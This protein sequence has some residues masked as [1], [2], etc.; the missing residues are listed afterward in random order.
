[1]Q[2]QQLRLCLFCPGVS[3]SSS[4]CRAPVLCRPVDSDSQLACHLTDGSG[5][6]LCPAGAP[7]EAGVARPLS[8]RHGA[9]LAP[10]AEAVDVREAQWQ[11]TQ[12]LDA[13]AELEERLASVLH[14]PGAEQA[15][16][17]DPR[18][19]GAAT[20]EDSTLVQHLGRLGLE[21]FLTIQAIGNQSSM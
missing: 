21:R 17:M 2:T 10:P 13:L 16:M 20:D 3:G 15:D 5:G 12:H 9:L 7:Q 19:D 1:M 14:R 18:P 4:V 8:G 11:A 6:V